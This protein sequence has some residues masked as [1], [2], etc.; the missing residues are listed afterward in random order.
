MLGKLNT[1]KGKVVA[2]GSVC[3]LTVASALPVLAAGETPANPIDGILETAFGGFKSDVM[4]Y[5]AIALPI[6]LAV[7]GVFWGIKRVM[8]F[9]KSVA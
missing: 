9:F 5:V 6:G 7:F 2:L 4:G 8:R 3:A 1:V